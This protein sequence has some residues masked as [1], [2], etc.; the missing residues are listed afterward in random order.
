[1]S[2]YSFRSNSIWSISKQVVHLVKLYCWSHPS[3]SL[4]C[5]FG[6]NSARQKALAFKSNQNRIFVR[7]VSLGKCKVKCAEYN[8]KLYNHFF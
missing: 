4:T 7:N 1:M 5:K 6:D 3:Q 8:M 2:S